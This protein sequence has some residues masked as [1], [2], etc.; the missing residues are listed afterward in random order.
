MQPVREIINDTSSASLNTMR[1][2]LDGKRPWWHYHPEIELTFMA[3]GQARMQVGNH[4]TTCEAGDL[5]VLGPDL[6]HD[7]NPADSSID[8][9]FLV[10]QF[11]HD[12]LGS[13]PELSGINRFLDSVGG[14]LLL[15]DTPPTL[16]RLICDMDGAPAARRLSLLLEILAILA[17][18]SDTRWQSLSRRGV[19]RHVSEGTN[20]RRLQKVIEHILENFDRRISLDEMASLVHMATPSF[21]R[22]FRRTIEMTFTDYVNRVRVEECCRQLRFTDKRITTI[23]KD[24]G[25]NSFSSFNRQFRRLKRCSPGQWRKDGDRENRIDPVE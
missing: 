13:F 3:A 25:F 12:L 7:F 10:L 9:D 21:S 2:S 6:P 22:W 24:S 11:R 17:E 5:V 19:V 18:V 14:G 15:R 16:E 4:V 1:V 20:H 23:A 8:C